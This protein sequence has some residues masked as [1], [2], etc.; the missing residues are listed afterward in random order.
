M[1]FKVC[2]AQFDIRIDILRV[3]TNIISTRRIKFM[4]LLKKILLDFREFD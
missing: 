1:S 3:L 4:I 2:I